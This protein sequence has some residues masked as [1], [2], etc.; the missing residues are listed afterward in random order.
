MNKYLSIT[1]LSL[2][3]FTF[4]GAGNAK[5]SVTAVRTRSAPDID[6]VIDDA[7]WEL[8]EPASGF[9]RFIPESGGPAPVKTEFR[10][11][12][13]D[14][15]FYVAIVMYDDDPQG[16]PR[17]LGARDDD[18]VL[19]DWIGLWISPF[20]DGANEVNFRVTS[21]GVQ[22]DRKLTQ[23]NSDANWNP[24][25]SGD[26]AFN[27]K[28][29]SVEMAIPFSQIRFP[30]KDIQTWGFNVGRWRARER[31]MTT[32]TELD[33][34]IDNKAQ[35]AGILH[36]IEQIETPLR[37]SL[38]P[39]AS[40]SMNHF[41]YDEPGKSNFSTS[42][43]GGMDLKYGINESF[44]LDMTLIPDFGEVQSDNEVL[45]LTPFEVQYDEHRP[46]FTEGIDLLRKAGIF[47]S[48]RVG[49]TPIRHGRVA[50]EDDT[51]LKPGES[52]KHNPGETQLYNATKITGQ[53]LN[54]HGVGFF[55]A[56]TAPV[57]ATLVDTLGNEREH[58]TN[59]LTNYNLV[60]V[61]KN[62]Q[63]GSEFS[64]INTNVQRFAS[65]DTTAD[66]RDANVIGFE[67]RLLTNDSKW[68]FRGS[69]AYNTLSYP[70]SSS[71]G[72]KY[73]FKLS[74][75]EGMVLY[76]TGVAVES[77]HFD[78][79]DLGFLRQGNEMVH[80]AWARVKTLKPVG[81]VRNAWLEIE[82]VYSWLYKPRLYSSLHVEIEWDL[83]FNNHVSTGGGI[84]IK[85]RELHDHYEP[86][87]ASRFYA[88]PRH[89]FGFMWIGSNSN[90][91][92]SVSGWMGRSTTTSNG[93][94]WW[95]MGISPSWR[96][97][98]QFQINYSLDMDNMISDYGFADFDSLDNPIFGR[99][100]QLTITNTINSQFIFSRDLESRLRVRHYRA[101]VDY[102]DYYDLLEN[103]HL[104]ARS[105][106]ANLD[107][108]F[109][110]FTIDAVMTW[111]FAPGSE[112]TMTW[113]NA[114]YTSDS[115]T[116]L[117]YLD[118]LKGLGSE[119][120]NNTISLKLLYY[121]DAWNLKHRF[122]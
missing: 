21:A 66:F 90:K 16:I 42:Y 107:K 85:P 19:A 58:L 41:P 77:E 88:I 35:Q 69:G 92:F 18:G 106:E 34:A 71:K 113:K 7:V 45:N 37:L 82:E 33:P 2:T 44:T 67:T 5:K 75:E 76:G 110:A 95:G 102:H 65:D 93:I 111:R 60:V 109:N 9:F 121:V 87:V 30:A 115:D 57:Y 3:L 56:I 14:L 62:L 15:A 12:Y 24:V 26:L 50:D 98:N 25:W 101:S 103:G 117:T 17:Q 4:A 51:I 72:Y 99:R 46:F 74:E 39:Y 13:D 55:N 43:R 108:V 32:W 52:V 104:Q 94:H 96:V 53:T 31:D 38:T 78:P 22:I 91:P 119:D 10:I 6:G 49:S 20:N 40:T 83:T 1:L 84:T 114:I 118:D 23:T 48:R 100:D 89:A 29:W 68:A 36:G 80:F 73:E 105:F 47:Y 70:D 122:N 120:Q 61:S 64:V 63:R 8:A 59:P 86:R 112:L 97:N 27:D 116:D 81:I 54:G 28:G 11:L 79:N